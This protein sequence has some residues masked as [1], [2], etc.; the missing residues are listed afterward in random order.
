MLVADW[1]VQRKSHSPC[2]DWQGFPEPVICLLESWAT[3]LQI[4]K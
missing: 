3:D 1:G 4:A 2:Q